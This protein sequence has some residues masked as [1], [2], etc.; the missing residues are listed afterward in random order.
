MVLI[1]FNTVEVD[2]R[3]DWYVL[4]VRRLSCGSVLVVTSTVTVVT[5]AI[6]TSLS[7]SVSVVV[8]VLV[9][10]VVHGRWRCK[11]V[12]DVRDSLTRLSRVL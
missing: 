1:S 11:N 3:T 9:V 12:V 7:L 5:R 2:H 10:L 8:V 6:V 4:H